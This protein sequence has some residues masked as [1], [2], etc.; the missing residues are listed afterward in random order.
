MPDREDIR[1]GSPEERRRGDIS[2]LQYQVG[3]LQSSF[4]RGIGA[5]D[6]TMEKGFDSLNA[7]IDKLDARMATVEE[8]QAFDAARLKALEQFR[9]EQDRRE[10][11][12]RKQAEAEARVA[13]DESQQARVVRTVVMLAV[14]LV[15]VIGTVVAILSQLGG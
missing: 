15:G 7:R 1:P 14:G 9:E 10:D 13:V 8:R 4:D 11:E 5:L 3:A 2:V 12:R 6:K